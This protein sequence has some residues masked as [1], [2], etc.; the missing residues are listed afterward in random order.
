M[1]NSAP[2][3]GQAMRRP[4]LSVLA[5]VFFAQAFA[6]LRGKLLVLLP[7]LFNFATFVRGQIQV[8]LR[9]LAHTLLAIGA[10]VVP[11]ALVAAQCFLLF[12]A[13]R[14]PADLATFRQIQPVRVDLRLRGSAAQQKNHPK[15][16]GNPVGAP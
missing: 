13:Q 8:A 15:H 16:P 12:R 10:V 2:K 11:L 4:A 9:T 6:F 3:P 5:L 1:V 14:F 7:L